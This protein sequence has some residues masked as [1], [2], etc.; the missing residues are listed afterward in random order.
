MNFIAFGFGV[1]SIS[2][3]LGIVHFVADERRWTPMDADH[4]TV[5]PYFVER[6]CV[7]LR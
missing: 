2:A 6:I 1:G 5:R 7:H 3:I 4:K